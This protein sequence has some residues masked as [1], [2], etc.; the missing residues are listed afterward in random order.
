MGT[1]IFDTETTNTTNPEVIEAAWV[2]ILDLKALP[3]GRKFCERYRPEG[4]IS[5][6]AM[7]THHIMD[8][9]LV[10]CEPSSTFKLPAEVNYLIGHNIDFDWKVAGC[11]NVKRICTLALA[12]D[13]YPEADSHTLSAMLYLLDR[14]NA[15][16]KLRSAH[17]ALTD[18]LVCRDVLAAMLKTRLAHISTFEELWQ[19]SEAAK[20]P[21]VMPFGKHKGKRIA[22]VPADYRQWLLRQPEVDPY[23][24]KALRGGADAVR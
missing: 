5:L 3:V 24:V 2:E 8:E 10:Y 18:V 21:K 20:I 4:R 13:L 6:G 22:D 12:R 11:P 17:S 1:F 15:R 19:A 16:D 9:D 7:A 14:P 23:L